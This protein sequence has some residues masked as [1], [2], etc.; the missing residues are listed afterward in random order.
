VGVRRHEGLVQ[1]LP[2]QSRVVGNLRHASRFGHISERCDEYT[3]VWVFGSRRKIFR[4]DRIVIEI[5]RRVEWLVSCFLFFVGF[6]LLSSR[7]ICLALAMSFVW[8]AFAPPAN[9]T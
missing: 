9:K 3:R 2:A 5:C 1:A 7:A 8:V 4:N 6:A